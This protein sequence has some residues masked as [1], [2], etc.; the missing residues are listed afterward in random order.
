MNEAIEGIKIKLLFLTK[1]FEITPSD[2]S[3][4][5]LRHCDINDLGQHFLNIKELIRSKI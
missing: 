1:G 5:A 2:F 4:V 3:R